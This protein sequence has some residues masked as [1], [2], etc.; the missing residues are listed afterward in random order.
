MFADRWQQLQEVYEARGGV[1]EIMEF[2]G[3]KAKLQLQLG[4]I[5][6]FSTAAKTDEYQTKFSNMGFSSGEVATNP[7][8]VPRQVPYRQAILA[9]E[10]LQSCLT[11]RDKL[12]CLSE[13]QNCL[14]T[15]VVDFHKGKVSVSDKLTN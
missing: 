15:A 5:E 4:S 1:K 14:K 3:I 6:G 12:A 13:S 10:K 8:F 7:D 2:L 11:P 9:L